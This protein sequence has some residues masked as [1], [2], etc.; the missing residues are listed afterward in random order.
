M[1]LCKKIKAAQERENKRREKKEAEARALKEKAA[2]GKKLS[3]KERRL[4]AQLE[5]EEVHFIF[6]A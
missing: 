1:L 3:N 4:L 2:S 6:Y 5:A